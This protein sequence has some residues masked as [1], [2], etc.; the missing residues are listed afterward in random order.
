MKISQDVLQALDAADADGPLLH[1]RGQLDRKT[2]TAVAKVIEAAGGMWVR[3]RGAHVFDGD[4]AEAI[5]PIDESN[6][7]AIRKPTIPMGN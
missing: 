3:G 1:L 7:I 2:Y 6:I 5:E 4:A